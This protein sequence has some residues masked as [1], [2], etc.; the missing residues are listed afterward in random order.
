ML[1][2]MMG[3]TQGDVTSNLLTSTLKEKLVTIEDNKW[4]M[5]KNDDVNVK[6]IIAATKTQSLDED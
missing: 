4:L 1:I 2:A 6:Y 5:G 3:E